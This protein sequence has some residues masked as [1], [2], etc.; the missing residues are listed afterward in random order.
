M[1]LFKYK[2][3]DENKDFEIEADYYAVEKSTTINLRKEESIV[4]EYVFYKNGKDFWRIPTYFV[5]RI[6]DIE[7]E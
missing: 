1:S 4:L 2:L 6:R 3:I 7:S 5:E